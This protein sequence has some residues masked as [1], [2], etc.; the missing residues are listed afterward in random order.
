[1]D[2]R[3][4]CETACP[5]DFGSFSSFFGLIYVGHM[6]VRQNREGNE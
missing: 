6:R 1:M 5:I 2:T 3:G 4:V